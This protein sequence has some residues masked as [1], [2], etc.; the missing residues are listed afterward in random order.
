GRKHQATVDGQ[1]GQEALKGRLQEFGRTVRASFPKSLFAE[2]ASA[3][4]TDQ[5]SPATEGGRTEGNEQTSRLREERWGQFFGFAPA[6]T[7]RARQCVERKSFQILQHCLGQILDLSWRAR[8]GFRRF[9]F[10]HGAGWRLFATE[11]F[12][13]PEDKG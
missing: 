2:G 6:E 3:Q 7:R 10:G 12:L 8:F 11:L 1:G 13:H 9:G 4:Q 5:T